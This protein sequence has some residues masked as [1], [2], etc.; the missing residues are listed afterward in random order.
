MIRL[1]SLF[2][3]ASAFI[4]SGCGAGNY[5]N[6]DSF[7][8]EYGCKTRCTGKQKE[9]VIGFWIEARNAVW[10]DVA[11]IEIL[12]AG[13]TAAIKPKAGDMEFRFDDQSL[14]FLQIPLLKKSMLDKK[15]ELIIR[16]KNGAVYHYDDFE[17]SKLKGTLSVYPFENVCRLKNTPV[18]LY[19]DGCEKGYDYTL[20]IYGPN[21]ELVFSQPVDDPELRLDLTDYPEG[22]YV[23]AFYKTDRDNKQNLVAKE[24]QVYLVN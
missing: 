19:I 9:S 17:M 16:A 5:L 4:L 6:S 21:R 8:I 1:L 11:S 22:E 7:R 12:C 24:Y 20:E 14:V 18:D 13:E 3:I 10:K 23:I 2:F 15:I